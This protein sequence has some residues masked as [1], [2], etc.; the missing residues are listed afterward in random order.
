MAFR[1][2]W[3]PEAVEDIESIARYIEKDSAFYA[4]AVVRKIVETAERLRE[5]PEMGR[6]VPELGRK[7]IREI[8][9][10]SYRM[11]YQLTE[12][13]ILVVAIIHA[14]RSFENAMDYYDL[15]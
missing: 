10:Y 7:D 13:Q 1:L 2:K 6:I 5:F 3:S 12:K 4:K 9:I 11:V 15:Q 8:I 14:K